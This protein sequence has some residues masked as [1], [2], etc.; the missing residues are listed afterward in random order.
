MSRVNK[1]LRKT[2][3]SNKLKAF[4]SKKGK[5]ALP[6]NQNATDADHFNIFWKQCYYKIDWSA[7]CK[8]ICLKILRQCTCSCI[9]LHTTK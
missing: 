6:R 7:L 9:D 3:R 1:T 2:K 8:A 4:F 5:L